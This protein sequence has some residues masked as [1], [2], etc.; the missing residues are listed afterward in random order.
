M[1]AQKTS[2]GK[3]PIA[4]VLLGGDILTYSYAREF[5]RG[6][7]D[8]CPRI[9]LLCSQDVKMITTTNYMEVTVDPG[10]E[11]KDHL[12][13]VTKRLVSKAA[14]DGTPILLGS[15]DW[16][17]E[18]LI[19]HREELSQASV[20]AGGDPAVIPYTDAE[21]FDRVM[22]KD[23]FYALCDEVGVP[24]PKTV[25]IDV[26]TVEALPSDE[27]LGLGWPVILKPADSAAW[28]YAEFEGKE[29]VSEVATRERLDALY[30]GVRS[31]G[32][33]GKLILQDRIPG[34][35]TVIYT[36]TVFS[37]KGRLLRSTI[38]H[39]LLQDH[40]PQALGNP[41]CIIDTVEE[42][43]H[44][45]LIEC[46]RRIVEHLGYTGY[47][48]FDVMYDRRDQTYRFLEMNARPGRNSYYVSLAGECFVSPIVRV[49][50]WGEELEYRDL[51]DRFMF[52]VVPEVLV[53]HY[54]T[55]RTLRNMAA[56]RR[57]D[58]LSKSPVF[59]GSDTFA[60]NFWGRVTWLHQLTKF[61][62]QYKV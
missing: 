47:G 34:D 50:A 33:G 57:K 2:P 60:H 62:R 48:N 35:D 49:L 28:H 27:E 51:D 44:D 9:R 5:R 6:F 17:A 10:I 3:K 43:C 58:G 37:H 23:T 7:G 52:C 56:T 8:L 59:D 1:T 32:Y 14:G 25:E 46:S 4:P 15:G 53:S 40:S 45:H 54:V 22:H 42:A 55:D 26:P 39:V 24:C 19:K 12:L 11:D 41:V 36:I 20:D 21:T 16:Y 29:K 30:A 31:S 61:A 13:E 38:G 18:F